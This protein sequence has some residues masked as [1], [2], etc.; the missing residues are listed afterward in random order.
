MEKH[1]VSICTKALPPYML[2][3]TDCCCGLTGACRVIVG[4]QAGIITFDIYKIF[5]S[6]LE[7]NAFF[8]RS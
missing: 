5:R 7:S 6:Q 1:V 4:I 3:L 2:P 8:Q